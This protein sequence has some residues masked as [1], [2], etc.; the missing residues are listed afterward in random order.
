MLALLAAVAA[1][2][3]ARRPSWWRTQAPPAEHPAEPAERPAAGNVGTPGA[4]QATPA[5]ASSPADPVAAGDG[6]GDPGS[7]DGFV[8]RA[9]A[10]RVQEE[11][12]ADPAVLQAAAGTLED[13]RHQVA[14]RTR[15]A[16][17]DGRLALYCLAPLPV[18]VALLGLVAHPSGALPS[19]SLLGALGLETAAALTILGTLWLR[20]VA[21]PPF[22]PLPRR[23]RAHTRRRA[24]EQAVLDG[25]DHAWLY[26][27]AGRP[28]TEALSKV[29]ADDEHHPMH[30]IVT[31]LRKPSRARGSEPDVLPDARAVPGWQ[32]VLLRGA[33]EAEPA[34]VVLA[35]SAMELRAE[36]LREDEMRA[37]RLPL[38]TALP[39]AACILPAILLTGLALWL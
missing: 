1:L 5:G 14:A 27:V 8:P 7:A 37:R 35:A 19:V 15:A 2:L 3:S 29:V 30:D 6:V 16:G 32:R 9:V 10:E 31:R 25:L 20:R 23:W 24:D 12:R 34:D 36:Q 11:L 38:A 39:F 26:A 21:R 33:A 18:A 17:R 4:T 28:L 22:S 13:I